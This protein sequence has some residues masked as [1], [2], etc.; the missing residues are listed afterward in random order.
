MKFSLASTGKPITKLSSKAV[1][2]PGKAI[3]V[4]L[5]S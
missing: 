2:A 3:N 5:K 1:L 4:R